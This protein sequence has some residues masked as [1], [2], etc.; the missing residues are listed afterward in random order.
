MKLFDWFRKAKRKSDLEAFYEMAMKETIERRPP[1]GPDTQIRFETAP[2]IPEPARPPFKG[3]LV[4]DGN[5]TPLEEDTI[6]QQLR[7]G[8]SGDDNVPIIFG[9]NNVYWVP[10]Q[11]NAMLVINGNISTK[12]L[13]R[14]RKSF[15]EERFAVLSGVGAVY[16]VRPE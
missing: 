7:D 15:K 13:K 8:L 2:T 12:T 5:L 10:Y 16:F 9:Y 3:I 11:K 4:V 6:E 14:L 1:S